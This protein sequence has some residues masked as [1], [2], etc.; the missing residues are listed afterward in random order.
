MADDKT[1]YLA[2][3]AAE[4]QGA[5]VPTAFGIASL[6]RAGWGWRRVLLGCGL[7]GGLLA[8]AGP[9]FA[10]TFEVYTIDL[11]AGLPG[12]GLA[13]AA[14]L[15]WPVGLE[16]T[17][18]GTLYIADTNN[19]RVR[20]VASDG[21]I[22][23]VAGT[24]KVSFSSTGGLATATDLSSPNGVAVA[25]D[26][27]LYIAEL[28][29]NRISK[30]TSGGVISTV[31]AVSDIG[32][33]PAAVAVATD[34]T[35][36]VAGDGSHRVWKIATDGTVTA[37][38]GTGTAGF[39][40]DDG[41]AASAK[42]NRPHDL[43]LA[44]DGTLYIADRDNQ[45]VRKVA[46]DGT[47]TTFAGT[48]TLCDMSTTP[49]CGD[50]GQATAADLNS[51]TAL[52]LASDGT[53][54]IAD[55]ASGH[56]IRAVA[57]DGTIS[58]VAGDGTFGSG[59]DGG[60]AT[61]A[62]L[63]G[64]YGLALAADGALYI[65]E[66]SNHQIRK[67]ASDG[68]ISTVVGTGTAGFS[69]GTTGFAGDDG[70]ATQALLHFP[71][72][73]AVARDGTL[74]IADQ[75]NHRIRV[76]KNGTITTLAGDGTACADP[77][78]STNP[79]GD[80]G[81]A[82]AAQLNRPYGLALTSD[83]TLY[84]ADTNNHRVRKVASDGTIS[85]FAGTGTA[86]FAGDDGPATAAQLGSP[87][88]LAL[89][90]DGTLYI[91]EFN[92]HRVRKVASDGTISTVA[93]T[94]T[95]GFAGDDG[96]ATAAQLDQPIDLALAA[97]GTLY[98]AGFGSQRIRKIATDGTI[99]TVAGAG[100]AGFNK[101][102]GAALEV[103]LNQPR[104]VAVTS[105]GSRV[106]IADTNNHRIRKVD[107]TTGLLTTIAGVGE[108]YSGDGGLA[109]AARLNAPTGVAVAPDGRVYIADLGNNR[110]RVL[111]AI[112]LAPPS[113]ASP[114]SPPA[115]VPSA[116][117]PPPAPPPVVVPPPPPPDRDGD[118]VVDSAE[119]RGD[120]NEDGIADAGQGHVATVRAVPD[121][122]ALTLAV[123]PAAPLRAAATLPLP[124]PA[125]ADVVLPLGALQWTV[126]DLTPG[127]RVTVTL[128]VPDGV[129]LD[130]F[131][132]SGPPGGA[133][134][135]WT[136][137][138][139]DG[140][141]GATVPGAGLLLLALQDGA[142]G[143]RDGTANGTLLTGGA[144][145]RDLTA[146][147][148]PARPQAG[149]GLPLPPDASPLW[150]YLSTPTEG[151]VT[152]VDL[153]RAQEHATVAVGANAGALA[154]SPTGTRVYVATGT[155]DGSTVAV[156]DVATQTLLATLDLGALGGVQDLLMA[157]DGRTL[158][159]GAQGPGTALTAHVARIDLP[160]GAL[161]TAALDSP[162]E[163][164]MSSA[165]VRL[166]WADDPPGV[167]AVT[168][169][170]VLLRLDPTTLAVTDT[171]PLSGADVPLRLLAGSHETLVSHAW[172]AETLDRIDAGTVQRVP[173]PPLSLLERMWQGVAVHPTTGQIY[174]L[175]PAANTLVA[176]D[177]A[178]TLHTRLPLRLGVGE[179]PLRPRPH[180]LV[181][182][183]DGTALYLPATPPEGAALLVL[184]PTR[185]ALQTTIPLTGPAAAP[186]ADLVVVVPT[187]TQVTGCLT[188]L[189]G[190]WTHRHLVLR[191]PGAAKQSVTTDGRG[192]YTVPTSLPDRRLDLRIKAPLGGPVAH[193]LMEAP[194]PRMDRRVVLRQKGAMKQTARTDAHGCAVF[195]TSLLDRR[196]DLRLKALIPDEP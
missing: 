60:Q 176:L 47:I 80:N 142:R 99:S 54:Y 179:V 95:A 38:A 111:K 162:G 52:A 81:A 96:P 147:A 97:D 174:G 48:G 117:S 32:V 75:F 19:H 163:A 49:D 79:C 180:P 42:L 153:V 132:L 25:S 89:A 145:G 34:G 192:C 70:P 129:P 102:G 158:Y 127:Q 119:G 114:P 13:T 26:G 69:N 14:Q 50:G 191:Q 112:T 166:A 40:G 154:V 168:G 126:A 35:L 116:P 57:T 164:E 151:R 141:T 77:T 33:Q 87:T 149:A 134:P 6:P 46:S 122:Q 51:P 73:V 181:L 110:I 16:L 83:G 194:G 11:V 67:V 184:D 128:H 55:G 195:A 88:G 170:P 27:T 93:G 159:A 138:A 84:I 29:N 37:F 101:E 125:P 140:T 39:S 31:A 65:A 115:P 20:K 100:T 187:P 22:T 156:L 144:P 86:G 124:A 161:T 133:G 76:V 23:T 72:G 9:V 185:P 41:Q 186:I 56:R 193:C 45:R 91:A 62:Q 24:G 44:S 121:G 90:S 10:Q 107:T 137:F 183:P 173:V 188:G 53:L 74:Y 17:S 43:A 157:P 172:L 66:I 113:P 169:R 28:G 12:D 63:G 85:T 175:S 178:G 152:V 4:G 118:G 58:T 120:G 15:S 82:T 30:V 5:S 148:S 171:R 108:G 131:W 143:D 105:D 8:V 21:T 61:E 167:W 2:C 136:P 189:Q 94:G 1:K 139:F 7:I 98:V 135:P 190:P 3:A 68:I 104:G 103:V 177:A 71:A 78:A 196:L 155:S 18:D 130:G 109:N 123:T 165:P 182:H 36:Y 160:T 59:G 64:P 150:A 146:P 106:Y 92:A